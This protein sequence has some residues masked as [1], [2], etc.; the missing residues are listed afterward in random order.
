MHLVRTRQS[1]VMWIIDVLLTLMAW[2]GLIWL[3]ARNAPKQTATSLK[4][5]V[6]LCSSYRGVSMR[7]ATKSAVRLGSHNRI[8]SLMN[9]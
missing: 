7:A 4:A 9:C 1:L 8:Q 5:A 6:E 2:A 3:L